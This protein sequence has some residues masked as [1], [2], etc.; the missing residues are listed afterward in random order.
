MK[1]IQNNMHNRI[2]IQ[3]YCLPFNWHFWTIYCII[4]RAHV[5]MPIV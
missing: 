4:S 3:Y 1:L 5:H 2:N